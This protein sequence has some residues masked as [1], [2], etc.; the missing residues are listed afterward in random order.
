M[1]IAHFQGSVS[2][3]VL[4]P[5]RCHVLENSAPAGLRMALTYPDGRPEGGTPWSGAKGVAQ[6]PGR[7]GRNPRPSKTQGVPPQ[8][9]QVE[10]VR[11]PARERARRAFPLAPGLVVGPGVVALEVG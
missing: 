1:I 4:F 2:F 5:G 9:G 6:R 8:A 7:L 10:L 11:T 3:F